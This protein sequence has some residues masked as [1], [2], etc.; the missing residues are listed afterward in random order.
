VNGWENLSVPLLAH[1]GHKAKQL[2]RGKHTAALI[3]EST[4]IVDKT[5]I[6]IG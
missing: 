2:E 6:T 5:L 3:S 1:C 4:Q